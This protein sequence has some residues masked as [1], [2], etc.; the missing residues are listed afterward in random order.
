VDSPGRLRRGIGLA[1]VLLLTLLSVSPQVEGPP[2]SWASELVDG[3]TDVGEYNDLALNSTGVPH[4]AYRRSD[5]FPGAVMHAWKVGAAWSNETVFSDAG[6]VGRYISLAVDSADRL[7][8]SFFANDVLYYATNASGPW[9]SVIVDDDP[10]AIVGWY[11]SIAVDSADRPRIAYYDQGNGRLKYAAYSGVSWAIDIVDSAPGDDAGRYGSLAIGPGD[12]PHIAYFY[13]TAAMVGLLKHAWNTG[14]PWNTENVTDVNYPGQYASLAVD[15]AGGLHV[16]HYRLTGRDLAYS[17]DDGTGWTT[18]VITTSGDV[19]L[20]TSIAL[21][22]GGQPHI[23][24]FNRTANAIMRTWRESGTWYNETAVSPGLLA[25]SGSLSLALTATDQPRLAYYDATAAD[26]RYASG[27]ADFL[28]LAVGTVWLAP[29]GPYAEGTPVQAFANVTNRGTQASAP[30]IARFHDGDPATGGPQIGGD[31]P[32]PPLAPGDFAIVGVPWTAAP[33]GVHEIFA[34]VNPDDAVPDP[35]QGNDKGFSPAVVVGPDPRIGAGDVTI[36]PSPPLAEGSVATVSARVTN[37]GLANATAIVVRFYD[38]DPGAGG[39]PIGGDQIIP[40]LNVSEA[41]NL[42]VPWTAAPLGTHALFAVADPDGAIPEM[43]EGNNRGNA[44]AL[45]SRSD[46]ALTAADIRPRGV[47]QEGVPG[48]LDVDVHNTGAVNASGVRVDLYLGDPGQGGVPVDAPQTMP[49]VAAGGNATA[50]FNWTPAGPGNFVLFALADPLDSILELDEANNTANATVLVGGVAD[51]GVV[52]VSLVPPPPILINSPVAV[53]A[54][55]VNLGGAEVLANVTF[56]EDL[57][58]NRLADPAEVFATAVDVR[59]PAYGSAYAEATWTPNAIG[60]RDVCAWAD[61][62]GRVADVNRSNDQ[63]CVTA[64]VVGLPDYALVNP[65]PVPPVRAGIGT[66][67]SLSVA[68]WNGGDAMANATSSVAFYN[69]TAPG[70]PFRVDPLSPIPPGATSAPFPATWPAPLTPG[71]Y[72]V[73]VEVDGGG[74]VPEWNEGNNTFTWRIDVTDAPI[75]TLAYGTPRAGTAPVFVTSATPLTLSAQ[76]FSGSGILE[77]RV[78]VDGV[79]WTT[80]TGPFTLSGEGSHTVE[81]YSEDNVGNMEAAN[82]AV[83]VL[84]ETPPATTVTFGQPQHSAGALWITGSTPVTLAAVD[85]PATAVGVDRTLYRVWDGAAWTA[86]LPF[87]S[88]LAFSAEA[89][90]ALE[91]SSIDVLGNAE[92]AFATAFRVD[93][94]P[95]AVL[96]DAGDPIIAG[97]PPW[98]AAATPVSV[99]AVDGGAFPVGLALVEYRVWRGAWGPWT[100]GPATFP[101][102]A[103]DGLVHIEAV[104][105]DLLGNRAPVWND[106]F[107]VDPL[108]PTTTLA[109]GDP[110]YAGS[111]LFVTSATPIALSAV[112]AGSAPVGLEGTEY[113]VWR[114]GWTAWQAYA[115]P[116]ALGVGD[117]LTHVEYRSTDLLGNG[118]GVRNETLAVDDAP[119]S[120]SAIPAGTMYLGANDVLYVGENVTVSASAVDPGP[121]ASGVNGM[122]YAVDGGAWTPAVASIPVAGLSHGAHRIAIRASD[123]L[124][125]EG[126]AEL[127]F[128]RDAEAPISVPEVRGP[129]E[130]ATLLLAAT[131]E[132]S[133]V[134]ATFYSLDGG[135]WQPYGGAI[136][137]APGDHSV[138][139]Y[140]LDRAGNREAG[141]EHVFAVSP[142]APPPPSA[143]NLKP[144]LAAA[145]AA[146]LALFALVRSRR[147]PSR[148]LL[149]LGLAFASAEAAT[150][151]LSFVVPSLA[152]PPVAGAGLPIDLGILLA[153]LLLLLRVPGKTPDE[154]PA[155]E[156]GSEDEGPDDEGPEDDQSTEDEAGS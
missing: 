128:F 149:V 1:L 129:P 53:N 51:V 120:V 92:T 17:Y 36:V 18:Q 50:S 80:Y 70:S 68:V 79:G 71:A 88:P 130:E 135:G 154:G 58:G 84:D 45:V 125:H 87:V 98:V 31:Q 62:E 41:Q 12:V 141:R 85:G 152:I 23:A 48:V 59:F 122:E 148:R 78:Q 28:D 138:L 38:G 116:F 7:H 64:E 132:G 124:G 21:D 119:P 95:P 131:D 42:S 33:I 156:Q 61:R 103:V 11:S 146:I 43:D 136:P 22:T 34:E 14:G 83:P 137:V 57:D 73:V 69:A 49:L 97:A 134:N 151:I 9:V 67:V 107:L 90:Y 111:V 144:V 82:L 63:Q 13:R 117:G 65:S 25:N 15:G 133:G 155:D 94:T 101:F 126:T 110:Q 81:F 108:P 86:W 4:I 6:I 54:S 102:G 104:A 16:S 8:V 109:V 145:F 99:G 142:P 105:E 44:S 40:Q 115:L 91:A 46:L 10:T 66:W 3:S 140:S 147:I 123:H 39:T 93:D 112:D 121:W 96:V 47:L 30:S 5:P 72:D 113:R 153:G 100:P 52:A 26:Q 139:F 2:A 114:G 19:G 106:S 35:F 60:V 29:A 118:E 76:D 75:T 143:V 55:L 20:F 127:A 37:V 27:Y 32:V 24:H 56:Y 89:T 74:A 150:G 77:T